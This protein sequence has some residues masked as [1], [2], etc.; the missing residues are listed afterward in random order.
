TLRTLVHV[1]VPSSMPT[2]A[3]F[4]VLSVFTHWN[5]YLWPLLVARDP[6]LYTPPLALSIFQQ[7]ETGTAY[8]EL[9]AAAMLVTLPIV[10]LFIVAQRKFV[11]G[12]AGG[13]LPG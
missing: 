2:I 10:V 11:T 5:D 9:A 12:I 3:A 8:G 4:A 1:V 7:A 13:E 6:S